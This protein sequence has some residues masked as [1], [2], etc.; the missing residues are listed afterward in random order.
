M[1]VVIRPGARGNVLVL[2][3]VGLL[4]ESDARLEFVKQF[5]I[6]EDVVKY[7]SR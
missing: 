6:P 1:Y 2:T 7:L 5:I 3:E 4:E